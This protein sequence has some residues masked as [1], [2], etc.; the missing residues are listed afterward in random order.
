MDKGG[1]KGIRNISSTAPPHFFCP[2]RENIP[3]ELLAALSAISSWF[4]WFCVV[5]PA[6]C[7]AF[8]SSVWI[9]EQNNPHEIHL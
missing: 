9:T 7:Q 2:R 6:D 5:P 3:E 4:V 8:S 1:N